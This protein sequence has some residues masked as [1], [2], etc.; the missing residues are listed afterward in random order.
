MRE[1]RISSKAMRK[2]DFFIVVTDK[3]RIIN[4]VFQEIILDLL[5]NKGSLE[6]DIRWRYIIELQMNTYMIV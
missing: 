2:K 6:K 5:S 1:K 4:R 3:D